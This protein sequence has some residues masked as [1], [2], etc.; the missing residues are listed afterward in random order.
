[1]VC[2]A[3]RDMPFVA[4]KAPRFSE[5]A[6]AFR[7]E[8]VG[9]V[10]PLRHAEE[11][12]GDEEQPHVRDERH[13]N[14]AG[15]VEDEGDLEQRPLVYAAG[16]SADLGRG[17]SGGQG[18]A[19]EDRAPQIG[20]SAEA[21]V[22]QDR[23]ERQLRPE[24]DDESEQRDPEQTEDLAVLEAPEDVAEVLP[25]ALVVVGLRVVEGE[26]DQEPY[27]DGEKGQGEGVEPPEGR[28]GAADGMGSSP[29]RPRGR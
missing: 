8:D 9:Q 24:E 25:E 17:E 22:H 3:R 18:G 28:E 12:R 15:G 10:D 20:G 29:F 16:E 13:E 1:M 27:G 2:P 19:G 4:M 26:E 21:L 5:G 11:D 6:W 14:Q 23:Q 7:R